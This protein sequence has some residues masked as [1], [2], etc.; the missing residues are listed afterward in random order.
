L[1]SKKR[2]NPQR[3]APVW[4]FTGGHNA[5]LSTSR[6]PR[7]GQC[8]IAAKQSNA[9]G[10][11]FDDLRECAVIAADELL[12]DLRSS[13]TDLARVVEAVIRDR[14]PYVVVPIQA[15]TSWERR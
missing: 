1:S 14:L 11:I 8:R 7:D 4:M 15:V 12:H 13:K 5:L 2:A 3:A 6:L 9:T 10:E